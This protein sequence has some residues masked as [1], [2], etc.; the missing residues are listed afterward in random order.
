MECHRRLRTADDRITPAKNATKAPT[1]NAAPRR[2]G[3]SSWNPKTSP[4]RCRYI[5]TAPRAVDFGLQPHCSLL[6]SVDP[7]GCRGTRADGERGRGRPVCGDVP[8]LRWRPRLSTRSSC[9]TRCS[10]IYKQ[11]LR[12]ARQRSWRAWRY[13]CVSGQHAGTAVRVVTDPEV[14]EVDHMRD[15]GGEVRCTA[16]R[17]AGVAWPHRVAVSRYRRALQLADHGM[18]LL[19]SNCHRKVTYERQLARGAA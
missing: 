1:T 18:Q 10:T 5:D 16:R 4:R 11:Q 14:L 12:A 13:V 15:N 17:H 19:C 2:V 6:S 8:R 9:S 7:V 3:G